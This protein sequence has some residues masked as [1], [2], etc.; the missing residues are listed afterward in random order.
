MDGSV[1]TPSQFVALFN[2]TLETAYPLVAIEG[3]LSE[4]RVRKNQWVY[5]KLKDDE[6]VVDF[7]GSV[8]QLKTPLEDGMLVRALARPRLHSRFGF[9]LN[10]DS[11]TP[12]G[13]GAIKR[14]YELLKQ[15]LEAKGLFAAE[16]KRPLPALPQVIGLISSHQAAGAEDFLKVLNERWGGLEVL[17]ANV[18]VQGEAAPEQIV[19]ALD[20]FNQHPT[21]AE[22]LV[23]VRGGGSAEDLSAFNDEALVRAIAASRLPVLVGVGHE[24]DTTLADLAA[25]KRAATPTEAAVLLVP[26]RRQ[27]LTQLAQAR[28]RLGAHIQNLVKDQ[29]QRYR[30]AL[31][32]AMLR[33]LEQS[34]AE[35]A[36]AKRS[37]AAYDP[38]AVLSRG[39]SILRTGGA[40]VTSIGQVNPGQPLAA[41]VA[42]GQIETEVLNV[43]AK[44]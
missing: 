25:D 3:E 13:E 42:D 29:V 7:F 20:Y 10:Y 36:A 26:D 43:K 1:L 17:F 5:F 27:L 31:K 6:A 23:V 38:K 28:A 40:V 34:Q 12:V 8:Y 18:A 30:Q 41:E 14:A 32:D 11:V 35:L 39:Y 21:A 19:R 37:L 9:S 44:Q 16:R 33:L 2:Q 24:Q 4:F 22:V 15:K